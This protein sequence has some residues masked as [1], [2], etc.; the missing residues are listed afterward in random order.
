MGLVDAN[1]T[2]LYIDIG[3]NGRISDD[4]VFHNC[5]LSKA[6]EQNSLNIPSVGE[7]P[8]DGRKLPYVIVRDDAFPLKNYLMKPYL[9]QHL[10]REKRIF[11]YR[12]SRA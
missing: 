12:L 6:L 4:G 11:N 9:H 2:F 5:H 10:S 3:Y 8:N 7:L 1:Y